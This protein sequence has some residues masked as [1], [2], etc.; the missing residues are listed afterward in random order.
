MVPYNYVTFYIF[1]RICTDA[2]FLL[3]SD[4]PHHKLEEVS[5]FPLY[6][7]QNGNFKESEGSSGDSDLGAG[8]FPLGS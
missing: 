7:L 2:V 3:P 1:Q 8:L 6:R 4:K 5:L